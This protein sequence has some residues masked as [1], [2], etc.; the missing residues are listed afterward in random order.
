[1]LLAL[2][3][4]V[5]IASSANKPTTA[6][7]HAKKRVGQFTSYSAMRILTSAVHYASG[8]DDPLHD[9]GAEARSSSRSHV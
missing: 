9:V 1:V 2:A 4:A 7:E 8:S 5:L 6:Q 3:S